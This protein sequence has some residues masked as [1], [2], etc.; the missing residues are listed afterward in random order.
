MLISFP[1]RFSFNLILFK[2]LNDLAKELVV[3]TNI[4]EFG[5]SCMYTASQSKVAKMYRNKKARERKQEVV[6]AFLFL[7]FSSR[8][9]DYHRGRQTR[10]GVVFMLEKRRGDSPV[11]N[12]VDDRTPVFYSRG[13]CDRK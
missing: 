8:Q 6:V 4:D 9:L 1:N 12:A 10:C 7:S 2:I 5:T 3:K 13:K 11:R